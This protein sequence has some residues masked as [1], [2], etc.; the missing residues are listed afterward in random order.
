MS[1]DGFVKQLRDPATAAVAGIAFSLILISVIVQFHVAV[2]SGQM[3]ADWLEDRARRNGVRSV[4]HLIPFAGIAFLWF[5]GV[6]RNRLGAQEDRLFATVL[7]GSGLL[8]VAL[9]FMSGA[10]LATAL[11]MFDRGI[12][13]G[14]DSLT[15]MVLLTK[16][17][18][19]MF[20]TRMAAVFTAAVSSIGLRTGIMP[21]WLATLGY[22][23]ALVL[24]LTPPITRWGQLVF[25]SWVLLL[26]IHVLVASRHHT[27]KEQTASG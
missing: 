3:S 15:T 27:P 19:G 14:A 25:P 21:K 5:M 2:P 18:M 24:M 22:V 13:V 8:F 12:P 16:F 9:L 7:L 11:Q 20:G 1:A 17:A 4:V 10:M 6:I 26:S 23:V